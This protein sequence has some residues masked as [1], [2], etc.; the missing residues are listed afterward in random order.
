MRIQICKVTVR[1]FFKP[2]LK[3][4]TQIAMS[5]QSS[6]LMKKTLILSF[7]MVIESGWKK[8][9]LSFIL[10]NGSSGRI[11]WSLFIPSG[12]VVCRASWRAG[13]IGSLHRGLPTQPMIRGVLSGITSEASNSRS[14][15][16]GKQPV[17]MRP[18][19]PLLGGTRSFQALSTFQ[20]VMVSQFWRMPYWTT[21]GS[22]PSVSASWV[23]SAG[24]WTPLA[25][26]N[27][28]SKR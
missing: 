26:G 14:Y 4:L 23:K 7:A 8:I 5:L 13:S 9:P 2:L 11:T 20:I 6:I 21:V 17:F 16:K 19:W 12:G 25:C 10:K 28:I 1:L 3:L 15:L 22:K 18:P 27:T 24:M